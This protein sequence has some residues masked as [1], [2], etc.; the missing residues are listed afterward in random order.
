[1]DN[2]N[3]SKSSDRYSVI[4]LILFL[5][6]VAGLIFYVKPAWDEV[7]SLSKGRDDK[8]AQK[9]A[10]QNKLTDLQKIQEQ[11]NQ[12]G[13]VT[14]EAS[15]LAI[16]EKF[17]EDNLILDVSKIATQNDIVLNSI[18]FGIPIGAPVGE[19]ARG[20]INASLVGTES[21]LIKFLKD[22]ESNG[23]KMLVKSITVQLASPEA[24]IKLANFS[25]S[26]ETYFQG[27]I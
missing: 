5:C 10:L 15:L 7:N 2:P 14:R 18:S 21:D 23:R 16:P 8:I 24:G 25:L 11:L 3:T 19:V 1:M 4:A 26:M 17:E 20:T 13:E 27:K 12:G 6:V 22:V 9:T